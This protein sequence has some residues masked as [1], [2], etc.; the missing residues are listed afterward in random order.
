MLDRVSP[1]PFKKV[2]DFEIKQAV[3]EFLDNGLP[4]HIIEAGQQP[5]VKVEIIYRAGAWLE[6]KGGVAYFTTKMLGEGTTIRY[7]KE[8]SQLVDQYGVLIEFH[9][10]LDRVSIA[11]YTLTRHLPSLLPLLEEI[12]FR[13][14]F[15]QEELDIL[16]NIKNQE[17][18]VENQK[19]HVVASKRIRQLLFGSTHPYGRILNEDDIDQ[20]DPEILSNY[21]KDTV[22]RKFEVFVSGDYNSEFFKLFNSYFG[23]F[24]RRERNPRSYFPT[25]AEK[26]KML[27]RKENSVQSSIR[28]GRVLFKRM[29]YERLMPS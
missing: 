9:P 23:N 26:D 18:Q 8:I 11:I 28:I 19:N 6:P 24:T 13:S 16:K 14:T 25:A 10:G 22:V 3:T 15:P 5:L 1:P 12:I 27:I 17:I 7:G 29:T 20:I 21:Y 2:Q 4:L